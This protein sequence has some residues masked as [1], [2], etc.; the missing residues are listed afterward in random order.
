M[1]VSLFLLPVFLFAWSQTQVENDWTIGVVFAILHL[2]LIPIG[3]GIV[4][5]YDRNTARP[6]KS[7]CTVLLG[8]MTFMVIIA[9]TVSYLF[10]SLQ[11]ALLCFVYLLAIPLYAHSGLGIRRIP[12]LGF[13]MFIFMQGYF[14]YYLVQYGL[15]GVDYSSFTEHWQAK[16]SCSLLLGAVYLLSLNHNRDAIQKRQL[17]YRASFLVSALFIGVAEV[18]FYLLFKS[19]PRSFWVLQLF[20][21]PPLAYLIYWAMKVWNNTS[22]ASLLHAMRITVLSSVSLGLCFISFLLSR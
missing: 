16:L 9:L 22:E 4:S 11:F 20:L 1:P 21:F 8:L 19:N 12:V 6:S 7:Q 5:L 14:A 17:G 18:L 15:G 2:L 10:F 13:L 3:G